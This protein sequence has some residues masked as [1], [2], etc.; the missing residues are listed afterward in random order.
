MEKQ[1]DETFICLFLPQTG[2]PAGGQTGNMLPHKWPSLPKLVT[3]IQ[4]DR[5]GVGQGGPLR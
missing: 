2:L 5:V 4:G 1:P 3:S